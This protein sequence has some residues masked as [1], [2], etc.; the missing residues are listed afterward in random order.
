MKKFLSI[1]ASLLF[2]L[3]QAASPETQEK[4]RYLLEDPHPH[5]PFKNEGAL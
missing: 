5:A 1:S 3:S 4:Y 2:S